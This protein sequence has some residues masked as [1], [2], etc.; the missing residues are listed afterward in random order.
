VKMRRFPITVLAVLIAWSSFLGWGL[1][2]GSVTGVVSDSAGVPQIGAVV[3][4]LRPD[5]SVAATVYTNQAGRYEI[6]PVAPGRYSIKAMGAYFLP[7]MREGLRVRTHSVV[8]LTLNTLYEVMQWLP[9]EPRA[10]NAHMDDWK[11][12]LRSAS[13]RPLLRWLEDGPLVVVSDGAGGRPKLKARL[14][15]TGHEGSFGESGERIQAGLIDTPTASQSLLAQVDFAPDSN[16]GIESRLGF[17][18]DLG[19]AGS[20]QSLAEISIHPEIVSAAGDG[21]ALAGVQTFENIRLADALGLEAGSQ[22]VAARFVSGDARTLTAVLP[23]AKVALH[24]GDATLHYGASTAMP[25]P[26]AADQTASMSALPRLGYRSSGLTLESGLHQEIGWFRSSEPLEASVTF[27]SDRIDNPV[28]Q[29]SGVASSGA[30]QGQAVGAQTPPNETAKSEPMQPAMPPPPVAM[31]FAAGQGGDTVQ[32][33]NNLYSGAALIDP[34]SG[35][36]RTTGTSY[37]A[38]GVEAAIGRRFRNGLAV[39]LSCANGN[40]L[41]VS[42]SSVRQGDVLQFVETV[43]PRRTQ[44]YAISFSGTLEGTGTR[45]RASYRWQPADTLTSAAAFSAEGLA[46]YLTLHLRQPLRRSG[47][48]SHVMALVDLRNLLAEGYQPFLLSDGSTLFFAQE[49]RNIGAGLAFTF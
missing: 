30:Q 22:V 32:K 36:L 39:R 24:Q 2:P 34:L 6:S 3:E 13:N 28:L 29:A 26:G 10:S 5:L 20:V 46:P 1:A 40:A 38:V 17:R 27:F 37:K 31:A 16:A 23:F 9:V 49:P 21:I 8:N 44:M 4:L 43:R 11:W 35:L 33:S 48:W 18:Q 19:Y 41:A 15:A 47:E 7:S 25:N 12:T 45:W 14:I 42:S